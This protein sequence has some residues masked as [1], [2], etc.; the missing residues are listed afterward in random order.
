MGFII[1]QGNL[2]LSRRSDILLFVVL[3]LERLQATCGYH[4]TRPYQINKYDNWITGY[5]AIY[6]FNYTVDCNQNSENCNI[7]GVTDCMFLS[8]HV[9][10]SEWIHTL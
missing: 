4:F 8:C 2:L 1:Q 7:N 6:E 3:S 5:S 9:R 10:V